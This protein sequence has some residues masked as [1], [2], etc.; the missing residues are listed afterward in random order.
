MATRAILALGVG[1]LLIAVGVVTSVSMFPVIRGSPDLLSERVDIPPGHYLNI[2]SEFDADINVLFSLLIINYTQG[3]LAEA[4]VL[5]PGGVRYGELLVNST[6]GVQTFRTDSPG[7]YSLVIYNAGSTDLD[8]RYSF[9]PTISPTDSLLFGVGIFLTIGGI[10]GLI[11]AAVFAVVD[12]K[13]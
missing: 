8:V 12:R 4:Y 7:K 2:S 10:V 13:R 11:V 1:A 6:L 9:G 3:D 5:G